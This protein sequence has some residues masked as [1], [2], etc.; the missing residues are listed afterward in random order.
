MPRPRTVSQV[1]IAR[2]LGVS[3]AT[4]SYALNNSSRVT[5]RTRRRV[6]R[7]CQ[8]LNYRPNAQARTLRTANSRLVGVACGS[9]TDSF[10]AT[11]ID[12]LER[13][14]TRHGYQM[15][16]HT[17]MCSARE[18]WDRA[19]EFVDHRACGIIF[20][21][22]LTDL[23]QQMA[24]SFGRM[25]GMVTIGA[26][27]PGAGAGVASVGCDYDKAGRRVAEHLLAMGRRRW[28]TN[29]TPL[30]LST[31]N[32]I[33]TRS[34]MRAARE[35]GLATPIEVALEG[36]Y[37]QSHLHE[38]GRVLAE[39]VIAKHPDTDAFFFSCDDLAVGAI[40]WLLGSGRRVPEDVAV[41]GFNDAPVA[42]IAPVPLSTVRQ[43]VDEYARL[44]VGMLVEQ[45]EN[46]QK[47]VPRSRRLDCEL[48]V[49]RSSDPGL[50]T[51]SEPGPPAKVHFRDP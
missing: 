39:A 21:T 43:P 7:M 15:L 4:V 34:F 44:A 51:A 29:I 5:E 3:Q 26:T 20:Q 25:F 19:L 23:H 40:A 32:R 42:R 30:Q 13:E 22:P 1:Q 49:R 33:K 46:R 18:C 11:L 37:Y 41:V 2:S 35:A 14:L 27:L 9:P 38:A 8:R 28:A 48:I 45:V 12:A 17:M 6:R 36:D 16:L 10:E 31:G 50:T 47:F 24:K